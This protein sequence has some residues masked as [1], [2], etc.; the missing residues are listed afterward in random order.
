MEMNRK[1]N[2]IRG[3]VEMDR[4]REEM[5]AMRCDPSL[6]G[7]CGWIGMPRCGG[8]WKMIDQVNN[9]IKW[10]GDSFFSCL[11]PYTIST[12]NGYLLC[13]W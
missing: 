4:L 10:L 13:R 8:G 2:L 6:V 9:I 11:S 1:K 12:Y 5:K 3:N 7:G